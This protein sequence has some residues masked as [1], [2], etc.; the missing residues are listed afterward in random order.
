MMGAMATMGVDWITTS[1]GMTMRDSKGD[2][3]MATAKGSASAM[4]AT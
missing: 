3:V 1:Q 4:A 2:L